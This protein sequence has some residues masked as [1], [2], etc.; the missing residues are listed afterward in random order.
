[1]SAV[2]NTTQAVEVPKVEESAPVVE[3]A[4]PVTEAVKEP[5]VAAAAP[6]E[7]AAKVVSTLSSDAWLAGGSRSEIRT[8][9][10]F[11][12]PQRSIL[13]LTFILSPFPFLS[14]RFRRRPQLLPKKLLR[15]LRLQRR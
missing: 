11:T 4:A 8:K 1:M 9:G 12:K 2:E 10:H 6:V 15:R 7:E 5:E 13:F 3:A 14:I